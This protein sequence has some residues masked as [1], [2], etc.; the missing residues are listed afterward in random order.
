MV[1]RPGAQHHTGLTWI[2]EGREIAASAY[3]GV[4]RYA[5]RS[6]APTGHLAYP[7]SHLAIAATPDNK[8]IRTGNQDR[9]V[10]I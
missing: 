3:G 2:R 5:P 1:H 8:W 10:H 7:G 9:S 6:T 4:H